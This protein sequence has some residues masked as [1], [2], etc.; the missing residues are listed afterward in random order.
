MSTSHQVT[1]L[2]KQD[3]E[4][5]EHAVMETARGRWFLHEYAH[6][7]RTAD[8]NMLLTAIERIEDALALKADGHDIAAEEKK[9]EFAAEEL[10][11]VISNTRGEIS[12]IR[13]ELLD[14]KNFTGDDCDPLDATVASADAISAS[15]FEQ[16][17]GLQE[18][19][20]KLR[21]A[22]THQM[23]C[24]ALDECAAQLMRISQK[25]DLNARRTTQALRALQQL[26]E[27]ISGPSTFE[28]TPP[29]AFDPVDAGSTEDE[30]AQ[31]EETPDDGSNDGRIVFIHTK[32][33]ATPPLFAPEEPAAEAEEQD[34]GGS[35]EKQDGSPLVFVPA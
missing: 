17:R 21:D 1:P 23:L 7:N 3:Y 33:P 8:T 12:A 11:G 26:D 6:R 30:H 4:A 31:L 27:R 13:D 25:Q 18:T 20:Y 28:S 15:I 16:A 22:G 9:P 29:L 24:N 19:V 14:D 5:I 10:A 32:G 35:S 2:R 34:A